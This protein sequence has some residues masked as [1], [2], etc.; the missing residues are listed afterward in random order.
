MPI[1]AGERADHR[2]ITATSAPVS[3]EPEPTRII[4]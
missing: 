4:A 1:S 2:A 3:K